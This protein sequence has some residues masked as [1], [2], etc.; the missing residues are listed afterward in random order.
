[1]CAYDRAQVLGSK[2]EPEVIFISRKPV[3]YSFANRSVGSN[4][5]EKASKAPSAPITGTVCCPDLRG[6]VYFNH[7]CDF[8]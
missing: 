3:L 1:M 5:P 6:V 8:V 4:L 7:K 2:I